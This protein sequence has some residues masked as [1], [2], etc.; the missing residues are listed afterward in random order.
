MVEAWFMDDSDA[1]QRQPHKTDPPRYVSPEDLLASTG[2]ESFK[3]L[4]ISMNI[5]HFLM[6]TFT[7][8]I[9][10]YQLMTRFLIPSWP[11][12]AR[13]EIIHTRMKSLVALKNYPIMNK[14]YYF[15]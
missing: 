9:Y 10:R 13:K 5:L 7:F 1:D 8:S 3:V 4:K 6:L 15:V 11:K 14:R 12:S 2:V